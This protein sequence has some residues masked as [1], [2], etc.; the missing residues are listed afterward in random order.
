MAT[1]HPEKAAPLKDRARRRF[2]RTVAGAGTL[3]SLS[4][5]GY[6]PV[7]GAGPTRLRPPGGLEEDDFLASCIKCGQCVQVCPVQAIRLADLD[8]GYGVGVPYIEPRIQACD[9]SCDAGQCIL[10]CP[11]GA[12]TYD[13]TP[14]LAV[15]PGM[16]FEKSPVLMA[17]EKD[18]EPTINVKER[19]GVARVARPDLCLARQGKGFKGSARGE[20]FEGLLRFTEVDRWR[21]IRLRDHP[22]DAPLCNLCV[23]ACPIKAA[24]SLEPL[25]G[26]TNVMTPVVHEPCLG[27]GTCEM[28]CPTEPA[29]IVVDARKGWQV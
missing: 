14:H 12:L 25:P 6:L 21:P 24:L 4:A 15:R 1:E 8:D 11:T 18:A 16:P 10:A 5:L 27:C 28:V 23:A 22:Y 17:K 2:L 20:A 29:A 3:L 19:M 13:K 26:A 7:A 9:F